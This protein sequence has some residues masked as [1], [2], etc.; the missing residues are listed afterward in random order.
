MLGKPLPK[1]GETAR[2]FCAC[3]KRLDQLPLGRLQPIS[4]QHGGERFTPEREAARFVGLRPC[5]Q[6]ASEVARSVRGE[7]CPEQFVEL[8][9]GINAGWSERRFELGKMHLYRD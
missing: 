5:A 1:G 2:M 4:D 6:G 9:G 3:I 8:D 7:T